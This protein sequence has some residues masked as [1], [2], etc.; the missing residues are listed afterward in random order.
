MKGGL[1]LRWYKPH[2][3]DAAGQVEAAQVAQVRRD[4]TDS[5]VEKA[6]K[7]VAAGL[8]MVVRPANDLHE[9]R[10]PVG[11]PSGWYTLGE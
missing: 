7:G 1:N 10:I 9:K 2:Q 8:E 5:R 4:R 6:E 11:S 3:A